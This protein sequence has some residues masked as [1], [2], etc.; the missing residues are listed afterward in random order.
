MKHPHQWW[1][2]VVGNDQ[3]DEAWLDDPH[4]PIPEVIYMEIDMVR[5]G[6]GGLL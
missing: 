5:K 6:R 3:I 2:G 4:L 1:Y